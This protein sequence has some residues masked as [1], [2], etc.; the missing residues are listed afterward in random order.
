M[1]HV[2]ALRNLLERELVATKVG[3][4]GVA[5]LKEL[6]RLAMLNLADTVVTNSVVK[7]LAKF[8]NLIC[9]GLSGI[10]GSPA[11]G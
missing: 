2:A 5:H 8:P 7:D 1:N 4:T 10:K 9:L 3:D 11:T 6:N